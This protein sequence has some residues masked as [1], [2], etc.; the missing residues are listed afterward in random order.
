MEKLNKEE[1]LENLIDRELPLTRFEPHVLENSS[2]DSLCKLQRKFPLEKHGGIAPGS[3]ENYGNLG[4]LVIKPSS[5][6]SL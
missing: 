2:I 5:T 4:I 6:E 3:K 1:I